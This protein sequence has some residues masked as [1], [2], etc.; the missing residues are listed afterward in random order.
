[1]KPHQGD[2][3]SLWSHR[4]HI[5]QLKEVF[6][7]LSPNLI[8]LL[9]WVTVPEH[10]RFQFFKFTVAFLPYST[11]RRPNLGKF[12]WLAVVTLLASGKV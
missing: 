7:S 2:L 10:C 8:L 3:S 4:W 12:T 6:P 1:M 9:S 5:L 11:E